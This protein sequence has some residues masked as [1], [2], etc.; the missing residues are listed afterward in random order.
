LL[1]HALAVIA[2]TLT[3]A[4]VGFAVLAL[5]PEEG[6]LTAGLSGA[7]VLLAGA[8]VHEITVRR[9][10]WMGAPPPDAPESV[11]PL[12]ELNGEHSDAGEAGLLQTIV[13]Q[14]SEPGMATLADDLR[15]AAE[16]DRMLRLLREA[17]RRDRVEVFLQPIVSLPQRR[18]RFYEVYSRIRDDDG[19]EIGPDQYLALAEREGLIGAIDNLLLLRCVQIIRES[20]RRDYNYG[21]FVNISAN[22]LA[23]TRFISQFLQFMSKNRQ[24]VPKLIFELH[25][26]TIRSGGPGQGQLL[27]GLR[28]LGFAFSMDNVTRFDVDFADL[29]RRNV[30]FVKIE[31]PR[32]IDEL[33]KSGGGAVPRL[34]S[35]AA[36]AKVDLVVEKLETER[37]LVT[38][39]E[40]RIDYGQGYLFGAP[41]A[42]RLPG[43]V[44]GVRI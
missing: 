7:W 14:F 12:A 33:G 24:L 20:Q 17:L 40:Q 26:D 2:Y 25:Q 36:E 34:F 11:A 15:K 41:R 35:H 44:E 38:L 5:L 4:G 3:G 13:E 6:A 22:S 19:S 27:D 21:F 28:Q 16:E 1:Q 9:R 32:L 8:L 37:Q 31:A 10:M 23:D 18:H 43:A 42:A 30:R 39:L 29:D